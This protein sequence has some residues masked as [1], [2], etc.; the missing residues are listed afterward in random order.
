M[1]FFCDKSIVDFRYSEIDYA[2]LR[3]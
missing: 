1:I 2:R 3:P